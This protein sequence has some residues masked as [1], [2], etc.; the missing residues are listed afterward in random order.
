MAESSEHI[1]YVELL[2]NWIEKNCSKNDFGLLLAD[3]PEHN[4][5]PKKILGFVPDVFVEFESTI[6]GEA[7]S[8]NDVNNS[9]TIEQLEAYLSYLNIS[10]NST[11]LFGVNWKLHD[12]VHAL[13]NKIINDKSYS[14]IN[15]EI[16]GLG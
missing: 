9:H 10:K 16:L 4:E 6:I 7:K 2:I 14:N 3:H 12:E 8:F 13:I 1:K 5:K 15:Y 11:L